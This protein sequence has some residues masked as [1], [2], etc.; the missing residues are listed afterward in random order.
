M[1]MQAVRRGVSILL[2]A[3]MMMS[4]PFLFGC[5]HAGG[6]PRDATAQGID[7]EYIKWTEQGMRAG[8]QVLEAEKTADG[9]RLSSYVAV[10]NRSEE[11]NDTVETRM[12]ETTVD[13]DAETYR[14]VA[15]LL[16]ECKVRKWNGF[17]GRKPYVLDG[18]TFIF[19]ASLADGTTIRASGSNRYPARYAQLQSALYDLMDARTSVTEKGETTTWES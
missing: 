1:K 13:G 18:K 3:V 9:V 4:F 14:A 5:R 15:L 7:F 6:D 2:A 19:E 12:D 10:H 8:A 16:A 17:R 11:T